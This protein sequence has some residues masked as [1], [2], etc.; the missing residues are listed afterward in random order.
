[1]NKTMLL[2]ATALRTVAAGCLTLGV[3]AAAHAQEAPAP[4]PE[5]QVS[6]AK[7]APADQ[8]SGTST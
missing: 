3:V 6:A 1:M 7:P 2:G 8:A 5:D 4:A